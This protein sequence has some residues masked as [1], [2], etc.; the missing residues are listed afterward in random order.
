MSYVDPATLWVPV[1]GTVVPNAYQVALVGNDEFFYGDSGWTALALGT[2]ITATAGFRAAPSCSLAGKTVYLSGPFSTTGSIT[3]GATIATLPVG[4]RPAVI[5][6]VAAM[7]AISGLLVQLRIST[8][9][10]I[11]C[12]TT[13]A[14]AQTILIDNI[15]FLVI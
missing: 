6:P 3:G 11:T 4:Y 7:N 15:S 12:T 10:V 9:G 8:A 13:I 14:T 2:N 1:A 5:L